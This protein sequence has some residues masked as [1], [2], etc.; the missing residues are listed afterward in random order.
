M[1][2]HHETG[3]T[4]AQR[5]DEEPADSRTRDKLRFVGETGRKWCTELRHDR[6]ATLGVSVLVLLL[7]IAVLAPLVAPYDPTEPNLPSRLRPPAWTGGGDWSHPLGTDGLGRDVLSRLMHGARMSLVIPTMVIFIGGSIGVFLG[8]VAG[9][10]GGKFDAVIMRT[11]DAQ[12]AFPGLLLAVTLLAVLGPSPTSLVIVL[13]VMSWMVF[14]RVTRGAVHSIKQSPYVEAAECVGGKPWHI[15]RRHIVPSLGAPLLTLTILE[16]ARLVLAEA[17]LSF[18]GL[19]VQP[20]TAS[21]GA[22]VASG[23][24]FI[25]SAWWLVT[26]PGVVIAVTVLSANIVSS[27]L[28]IAFDPREREKRVASMGHE[29]PLQ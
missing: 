26:F 18:L 8:V 29:P 28:R 24:P 14:A 1:S 16:F 21:W 2:I 13:S 12:F 23:R 17:S 20:P 25:F 15:V 3:M 10:W 4:G 11:V 9:Y 27:W 7:L 5:A 22:D 19:G 6:W